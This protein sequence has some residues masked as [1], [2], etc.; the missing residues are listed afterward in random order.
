MP[1][2]HPAPLVSRTRIDEGLFVL[3][4]DV[5]SEVAA[6][7]VAPG[8]FHQVR[9]VGAES[10]FA[11]GSTPGKRS[12]EYLIREG[13]GVSSALATAALGTAF[14]VSFP[15][16]RGF[17]VEAAV[18]RDL[19]LVC[20]GTALAPIRSVLG[21][22]APR[23]NEFGR[24]TLLQGQRTPAQRPWLDELSALPRIDV[25]TVVTEAPPAWTGRVGFVQ[26]YLAE[27]PVSAGTVAFLVG[28][29]AMTDEVTALLLA[30]G[31]DPSAVFL[32]V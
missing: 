25:H 11:I 16:G 24:V 9:H 20:T 26:Q 4:L 15:E 30:R 3:R 5:A 28:Q 6:R 8:Q 22:V 7:F 17:P 27:L 21:V 19:L 13:D 32:N 10:W 2:W 1:T 23:R 12:F 14:D 18:G 29:Q 31:V